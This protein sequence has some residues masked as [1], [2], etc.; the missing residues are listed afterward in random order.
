MN[1]RD[2]LKRKKSPEKVFL[3]SLPFIISSAT[4]IYGSFFSGTND[5]PMI[6]LSENNNVLTNI[7]L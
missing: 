6:S 1:I 5:S 2:L 7:Y 3:T 4:W